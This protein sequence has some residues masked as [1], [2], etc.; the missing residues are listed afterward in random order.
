[1]KFQHKVAGLYN[2]PPNGK[3]TFGN[4]NE[5]RYMCITLK[6][7]K[8]RIHRLVGHVYIFNDNPKNKTII[9]HMNEKRNDNRVENLQ[10]CTSSQNFQHSKKTQKFKCTYK[11]KTIIFPS[12][13]E[14]I[15]WIKHNIKESA[16]K[17]LI[18]KS[19]RS[20]MRKAYNI[21]FYYVD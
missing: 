10:W 4:K 1:M 3:I 17:T 20:G 11:E 16:T 21:K 12:I 14:V 13:N 19:C 5:Q 6:N 2:N 7:T 8:F 9:N 18:Q 15:E